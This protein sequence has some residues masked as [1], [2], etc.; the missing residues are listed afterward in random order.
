MG[1]SLISKGV[2]V[3][4]LQQIR[5]ANWLLEV[6]ID[7]TR[8]FYN[9]GIEVC[10]CLYCNN[11]LEACKHLDT[12]VANLFSKLGIYLLSRDIS[13]TLLQWKMD[14]GNP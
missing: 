10:S 14:Y 4:M 1:I 2:G 13:L 8:E 6:D 12:S 7:K 3:V 11:F 9:K 5:I